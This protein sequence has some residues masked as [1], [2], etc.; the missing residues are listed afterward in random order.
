MPPHCSST[1]S[2]R[3]LASMKAYGSIIWAV[4]TVSSQN[5]APTRS[6]EVFPGN[7]REREGEEGGRGNAPRSTTQVPFAYGL[8][9]T[10][11][12]KMNQQVG[13]NTNRANRSRART[14]LLCHCQAS[15]AHLISR[16]AIMT[17]ERAR[18]KSMKPTSTPML[19]Q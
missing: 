12:S 2:A 3:S 13:K 5:A 8:S 17:M 18:K 11:G 4:R 14:G 15:A 16:R 19:A 10:K 1:S 6:G 9:T 7:L